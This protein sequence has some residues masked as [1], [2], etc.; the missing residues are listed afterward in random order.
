M[1]NENDSQNQL[2]HIQYTLLGTQSQCTL[3]KK[4]D[5]NYGIQEKIAI[6]FRS[7][8]AMLKEYFHKVLYIPIDLYY[9]D[10]IVGNLFII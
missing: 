10:A 3:N 2:F 6:H 5:N 9:D 4:F 8:I 1:L 7:S